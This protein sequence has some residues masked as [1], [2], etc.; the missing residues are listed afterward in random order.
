MNA[1]AVL[2]VSPSV[3]FAAL[4]EENGARR[5]HKGHPGN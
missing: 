5:E 1:I 4:P 3:V 2:K